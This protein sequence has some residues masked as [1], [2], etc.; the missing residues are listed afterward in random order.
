MRPRPRTRARAPSTYRSPN[1]MTAPNVRAL[2][3]ARAAAQR[4]TSSAHQNRAAPPRPRG[5][6]ASQAVDTTAGELMGDAWTCGRCGVCA[7][8]AP[9]FRDRAEPIGWAKSHGEWRCLACR[10]AAAVEAAEHGNAR[11]AATV[12]R[13]ALTEFELLRDPSAP[14][15]VIAKRVNC[16][17]RVVVPIRAELHASGRLASPR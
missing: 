5:R 17:T 1:Q 15:R 6:P 14:D 10:R 8:F 2:T 7:S 12:R 16:P 4:R 11:G 9:G 13:R 3:R